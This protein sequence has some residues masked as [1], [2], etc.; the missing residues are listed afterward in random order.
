MID[1]ALNGLIKFSTQLSV[2]ALQREKPIEKAK[3]CLGPH[4]CAGR[5]P[6]ITPNGGDQYFQS[7][8]QMSG[9]DTVQLFMQ[10]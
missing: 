7:S 8:G 6:V 3:A 5:R 2:Y 10:T 1:L 4:Q 9:A